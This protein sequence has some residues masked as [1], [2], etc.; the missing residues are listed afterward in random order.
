MG[1]QAPG[2]AVWGNGLWGSVGWGRAISTTRRP[3]SVVPIKPPGVAIFRIGRHR[4]A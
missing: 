1:L 4:R 3:T 2:P